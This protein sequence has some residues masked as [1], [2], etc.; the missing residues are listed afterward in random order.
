MTL[1]QLRKDLATVLPAYKLPTVLRAVLPK[2]EL[3]RSPEGKLSRK[4]A[5][6]KFFPVETNGLPDIVEVWDLKA[7]EKAARKAWDWAGYVA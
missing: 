2:E 1:G 7:D 5:L 6:Q 3:P 4:P